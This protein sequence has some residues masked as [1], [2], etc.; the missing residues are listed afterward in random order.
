M[1]LMTRMKTWLRLE[2][3]DRQRWSAEC[4]GMNGWWVW[5]DLELAFSGP[6]PKSEDV[7]RAEQ[8]PGAGSQC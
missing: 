4:P 7:Q 6:N 1:R 2:G 8:A 3:R 5:E